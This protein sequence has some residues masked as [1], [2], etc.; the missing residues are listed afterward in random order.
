MTS[1][2]D[3]ESNSSRREPIGLL[4]WFI[5]GLGA[6]F[7]CYEFFLQVSTSVMVDD[8]MSEF[9]ISATALGNLSSFY[10]Y[11]YAIMQIPVGMLLDRFGARRLLTAATLFCAGGAL[12]F[13]S[14]RVFTVAAIGRSLIGF[15]SAFAAVSCMHLAAS[16]LPV[17]RFALMTGVLLTIG[18]L[19]AF[20]AEGPLSQLIE[21]FGWRHTL[22]LFG[23]IGVLLSILIYSVIRDRSVSENIGTERVL[24]THFLA[25]LKYVLKQPRVWIPSFY[26][27][28][29]FS[30]IPGFTSLW[31]V[32][33]L[34]T[35][36]KLPKTKAAFINSLT[37]IGFAVGAPLFGWFSDRIGRRKTPMFIGSLG[38]LI[39]MST[40]IYVAHLSIIT[41]ATLLFLFGFFMGGFLPVF[42][43]AR[44]VTPPET[45]ATTLGFVNMFNSFGGAAA[46]VGI[47]FILDLN[48]TGI[49]QAGRHVYD[50]HAYHIA[51]SIIPISILLALFTL[52]F[53]K[54][55]YCKQLENY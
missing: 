42:S 22:V 41:M 6:L 33:F 3:I 37:F 26:G 11:F 43:V 49:K 30:S 32:P 16:W 51:L 31:G 13:A 17:K 15:G 54:E 28:L 24:E 10:L 27:G 47:G 53:V 50:L 34:M 21:I 46:A 19:G 36:Y 5:W 25:G 44:E 7:Y 12:L 39:C 2:T 23:C 55:T 38:T 4:P 20:A 48:W 40:I 9:K 18:M 45:N 52:F 1:I 8:L 29:M 14:A 35:F